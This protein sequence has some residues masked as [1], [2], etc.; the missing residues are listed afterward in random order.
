VSQFPKDESEPLVQPPA[1]PPEVV[2]LEVVE[3]SDD[4]REPGPDWPEDD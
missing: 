1:D 2:H 4:E 3:Y